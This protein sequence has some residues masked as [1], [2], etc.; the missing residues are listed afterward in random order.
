MKDQEHKKQD[1][2]ALWRAFSRERS[3]DLKN[4]LVLHYLHLVKNIVFRLLPTYENYSSYDDLSSCG[5]LGLMDAIDK[6]DIGRSVKF[7]HY[8]TLRIRGE[9]IDHIRKQDWAPYSLRRKIKRITTAFSD[10]EMDLARK[11]T[12]KE[13][14]AHLQMDVDELQKTI[15][16]AHLFNVVNFEEQ[17]NEYQTWGDTVEDEGETP[18]EHLEKKEVVRVLG[19]QIDALPEREKQVVTLYYYEELTLREIAGIL[20]MSESRISQIHSK[21]LLKL[22]AEME[23]LLRN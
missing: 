7:E 19:E 20:G 16:K 18:D 2:D 4:E 15:S 6:Y 10:L 23:S 9:I 13:V 3:L 22:R 17:I 12:D 14:A 21:V 11:P 1:I 8:A 5:V